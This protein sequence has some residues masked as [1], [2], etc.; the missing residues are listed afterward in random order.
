MDCFSGFGATER[1]FRPSVGLNRVWGLI[2]IRAIQTHF[3]VVKLAYPEGF[4]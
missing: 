1:D 2:L 3:G 4:Y